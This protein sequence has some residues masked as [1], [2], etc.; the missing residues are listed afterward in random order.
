[1]TCLNKI[2]SNINIEE[3]PDIAPAHRANISHK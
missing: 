3:F 1:M 2:L